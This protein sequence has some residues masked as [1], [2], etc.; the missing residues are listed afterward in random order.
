MPAILACTMKTIHFLHWRQ[1]FV[2]GVQ[3][4]PSVC[5]LIP[6]GQA[7]LEALGAGARRQRWLQPPLFTAHGLR[8]TDGDTQSKYC[9]ATVLLSALPQR[10]GLEREWEKY[11]ANKT[12]THNSPYGNMGKPLTSVG[13]ARCQFGM[14]PWGFSAISASNLGSI[15]LESSQCQQRH[16]IWALRIRGKNQQST[17][18]QEEILSFV[19][20]DCTSPTR[21]V[22]CRDI[23][24]ISVLQCTGFEM[25]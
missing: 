16:A 1:S 22:K 23:F 7:Q 18:W 8:T 9:S 12:K 3:V 19:T 21:H 2:P 24:Y 14:S 25:F 4:F 15:Y 20:R 10:Q 17:K 5:R 6:V 11:G 13:S